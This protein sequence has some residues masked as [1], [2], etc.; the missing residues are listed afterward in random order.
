MKSYDVCTD[1]LHNRQDSAINM[2][3]YS[4]FD[5]QRC[6]IHGITQVLYATTEVI[7]CLDETED[8]DKIKENRAKTYLQDQHITRP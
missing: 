4:T 3:I 7:K 1:T 8:E 2:Q 5:I 6:K